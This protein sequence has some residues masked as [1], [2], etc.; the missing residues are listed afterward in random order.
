LPHAPGV[1]PILFDDHDDAAAQA[2]CPS[3]R[4]SP[5]ARCKAAAER[6]DDGRPV[7][8]FGTPLADL[9]TVTRNTVRFGTNLSATAL[10]TPSTFGG[11]VLNVEKGSVRDVG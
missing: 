1:D 8:S 3:P 10:A 4:V 2:Q 11:P 6:T 5:A 9:A 7:H